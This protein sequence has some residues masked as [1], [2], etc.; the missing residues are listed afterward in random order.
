VVQAI[1]EDNEGNIWVGTQNG[2]NILNRVTGKFKRIYH[3]TNSK[4]HIPGK[5]ITCIE[6]DKK[7]NMWIGTNNGLAC[8]SP[9][10][11]QF[12]QYLWSGKNKITIK[13]IETRLKNDIWVGT[14]KN[15]YRISQSMKIEQFDLTHP[16]DSSRLSNYTALEKL[17]KED[18]IL[19]TQ[20]KL[21]I[22]NTYDKELKEISKEDGGSL[23]G[24]AT[25]ADIL[26]DKKGK[27]WVGSKTNG[28]YIVSLTNKVSKHYMPLAEMKHGLKSKYIVDLMKD[29]EGVIWMGLKFE[30]VQ[31]FNY[32]SQTIE[33]FFDEG[34]EPKQ[35]PDKSTA[36]ISLLKTA[37]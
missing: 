34:T 37:I 14:N 22:Y 3:M 16:K 2:L 5:S 8:Y 17:N 29:S 13:D 20:N 24:G 11:Q 25:L 7:G 6:K 4:E 28:L 15:L 31:F 12:T 9:E 19:S 36:S 32:Q 30:G 21:F 27:L 10:T 18:I 1:G 33:H 35:M 23:T 26:V